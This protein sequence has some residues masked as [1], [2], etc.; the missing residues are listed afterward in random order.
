MLYTSL[1]IFASCT[2]LVSQS[3]PVLF[4]S[5]ESSKHRIASPVEIRWAATTNDYAVTKDG[6]FVDFEG[7]VLAKQH[8][9]TPQAQPIYR[10][11]VSCP[12]WSDLVTLSTTTGVYFGGPPL[13]T[14]S[15]DVLLYWNQSGSTYES[16]RLRRSVGNTGQ[17]YNE[18]ILSD[19]TQDVS[20]PEGVIDSTGRAMIIFREIGSPYKLWSVREGAFGGW[21]S[22]TLAHITDLFFQ[23][24]EIASDDQGHVI[25]ITDEG[26]LEPEVHSILF[27]ADTNSWEESVQVSEPGQYCLLPTLAQ[28]NDGSVVY[29]LY[30][31]KSGGTPGIYAHKWNSDTKVWGNATLVQSTGSVSYYMAGQYSRFPLVIGGDDEVTVFWQGIEND[32]AT[33]YASRTTNGL[34]KEPHT[35]LP[36][37]SDLI[38]LDLENFSHADANER[39][40]V[41]GTFTRFDGASSSNFWVAR[42]DIDTGWRDIENPLTV[43]HTW[44]VKTRGFFH[45]GER[46]IATTAGTFGDVV[47][48]RSNGQ[49]WLEEEIDIPGSSEAWTKTLIAAKSGAMFAYKSAG[50]KSTWFQ[51]H[52]GDTNCDGIVNVSDLLDVVSLWG[53]CTDF[54]GACPPDFNGDGIVNVVDL[55]TVI[56]NWA[57][58]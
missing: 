52:V 23:A 33:L 53:P 36:P 46:A 19:T 9:H 26:G 44:T 8:Q 56:D 5:L 31:I 11:L 10:G 18:N 48:M 4:D 49:H 21:G 6:Y 39:G 51:Y 22:P 32:M 37:N 12:T 50:I 47:G 57:S 55:L 7:R 45:Y 30:L 34:W 58:P 2:A 3:N 15:G 20:Q 14:T 28:N 13:I 41:L 27:N 17:W 16:L 24:I 25:A 1:S 35:L 29:L 43:P 54:T 38:A 42:F 40:D